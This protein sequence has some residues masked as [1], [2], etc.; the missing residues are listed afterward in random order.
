MRVLIQFLKHQTINI[1]FYND[2][3]IPNSLLISAAVNKIK[4]IS[5]QDRL[6]S[7][8][9][10]NKI[11]FDYYFTCGSYFNKIFKEKYSAEKLIPIDC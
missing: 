7:Y 8:V 3:I 1:S 9:Y 2:Y 11:I 5:F 6:T 4:S 10:N